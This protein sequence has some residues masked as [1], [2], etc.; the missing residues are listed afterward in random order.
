MTA[1]WTGRWPSR[2]HARASS[3]PRRRKRSCGK[4]GLPPSFTIPTSWRCTKWA[5][6]DDTLYIVSDFVKGI[7]LA[8]W[9]TAKRP[10]PKEAAELCAKIADA[11][12]HAHEH[13][14]IHRD[15][16]PSNIMLDEDGQPHIMDFGLAKREAGEITMTMEGRV[17][18]TPA[19]MSPEQA[20]GDAHDAD[21]RSDV[22]SLGV[23][24]F[25]LLTGELPFRG[26]A[27]MLIHQVINDEPPSP[28]RLNSGLPLDLDTICLK[29]L[30]KVPD[31]RYA[32]ARRFGDDLLRFLHEEPIHAR[33]ITRFERGWRWCKRNRAVATLL[34]VVPLLL[35]GGTTVSWYLAVVASREEKNA[36]RQLY[37]SDMP[38]ALQAW[39]EGN[40]KQTKYLLHR[41]EYN[42]RKFEWYYLWRLYRSTQQ[43]S[44]PKSQKTLLTLPH[45]G[46][47]ADVSPDES[48]LAVALSNASVVVYDTNS[49][50]QV[51]EFGPGDHTWFPMKVAFLA[52]GRLVYPGGSQLNTLKVRQ[53]TS[54][55][56]R[57][58]GHHEGSIVS[59][60]TAPDSHV[61]AAGDTYGMIRLWNAEKREVVAEWDAHGGWVRALAFSP[62]GR[63]LA[64]GLSNNSV[65]VWNWETAKEPSRLPADTFESQLPQRGIWSVAFSPNGRWLAAG[66]TDGSLKI[67]DLQDNVAPRV[68]TGHSD[69]LRSVLFA[70]NNVVVS[71]SRDN[72]LRVWDLKDGTTVR[73]YKGHSSSVTDVVTLGN[74]LVSISADDTLRWWPRHAQ[75]DSLE[76]K[77]ESWIHDLAFLSDGVNLVVLKQ[78]QNLEPV[79]RG[80][81]KLKDEEAFGADSL[82]VW[83]TQTGK[84]TIL[85]S[86]GGRLTCID[87]SKDGELAAGQDDGRVLIWKQNTNS[88]IVL[89]TRY[90]PVTS[91][92]FRSR[93]SLVLGV[94]QARS[95]CLRFPRVRRRCW[96]RLNRPSTM[97]PLVVWRS[98]Q[99][100]VI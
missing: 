72:T 69:E 94:R 7:T 79:M 18:G 81:I 54:H 40:I 16:K 2:S 57:D 86:V 33:P 11:V 97:S 56:E 38:L 75:A 88:P 37:L 14:V 34:C 44:H 26:N 49:W 10:T 65:L 82:L 59:L 60:A 47:S 9:L 71:T 99:R 53:P 50:E 73:E 51:N 25:E 70:D 62:D 3:R 27:R 36:K 4:P 42:L 8:D 48:L 61:V 100:V 31:R 39:E 74:L 28:R 96:N 29:C 90:G 64:C 43:A 85:P 12:Q 30:E 21:E 58:I 6:Q 95:V 98:I 76:I 63:T 91:I 87:T 80:K 17:L 68:L 78:G 77:L 22:Y 66:S 83:N 92:A 5:R 45:S 15:L 84:R 19:Y 23:I 13:G 35:L 24:L 46:L 41:H 55:E 67:W 1:S 89:K 20:K 52:D 93:D 32:D